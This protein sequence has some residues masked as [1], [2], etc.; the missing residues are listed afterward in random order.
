MDF[1]KSLPFLLFILIGVTA[2]KLFD[3][4]KASFSKLLLYFLAPMVFFDT[5]WGSSIGFSG[6]SL[7]LTIAIL[8][9]VLALVAFRVSHRWMGSPDSNLLAFSMGSAN[10]GYFGL[11]VAAALFGEAFLPHMALVIMGF[12]LFEYTT[13]F[14]ITARSNFSV[15][16]SLLKLSRLPALYAYLLALTFNELG[17]SR[18]EWMTPLSGYLRGAY[19]LLGLAM[20]GFGLSDLTLKNIEIG[21]L[22]KTFVSRFLMWPLAS[23]LVIWVLRLDPTS[24]YFKV[25]SLVAFLPMAANGVAIAAELKVAPHKIAGAIAVS[26]IASLLVL[27]FNWHIKLLALLSSIS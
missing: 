3:L 7:A 12:S 6:L 24:S 25:F 5:I 27:N 16:A 21:F 15:R 11:P 23:A 17:I 19:T 10:S 22:A 2:G 26:T 9:S 20:L 13:G 4:D 8:A 18:G 1:A 14:Y